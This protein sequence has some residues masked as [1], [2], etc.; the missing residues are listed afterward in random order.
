MIKWFAND[1]SYQLG[2]QYLLEPCIL[3]PKTDNRATGQT[4]I[5][6][7]LFYGRSTTGRPR[8]FA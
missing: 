6:L 7:K 5:L 2:V 8:Q 3:P 1:L 4:H